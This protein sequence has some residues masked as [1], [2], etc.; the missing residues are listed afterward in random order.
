[1]SIFQELVTQYGVPKK[2]DSGEHVFLQ[3]E[4]C[5]Q[6][7]FVKSGLLKSYYTL[8][9]GKEHIKSFQPEGSIIS[10]LVALIDEEPSTFSLVALEDSLILALPYARLSEAARENL[11][12]SNALIDFLSAYGRR[13]ERREYELL[14]MAPEDRYTQLLDS[15]PSLADRVS[16]GDL[17]AYVGVTPQALSRIKRRIRS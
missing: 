11:E 13:K 14:C 10:S 8:A 6:V 12:L 5:R 7:F 15:S 4:E 1:M 2:I 16:Q 3:G 17:A 9:D